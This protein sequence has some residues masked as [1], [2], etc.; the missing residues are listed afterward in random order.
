MVTTLFAEIRGFTPFAARVTPAEAVEALNEIFARV[1]EIVGGE[2]G[3]VDRVLGDGMLAIF[4]APYACEQHASAAARAALEVR[5]ALAT[6]LGHRERRGKALEVGVGLN[7]GS[8]IAGAVAARDRSA[9]TVL[10]HAVNVAAR[11]AANADAS[12]ILIGPGTAALLPSDFD[13]RDRGT[14]VLPGIGPTAVFEL[15]R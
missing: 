4:G 12:Q 2:Q 11:L 9:Y 7:T 13:V 10:G 6:P 3:I 1:C 14:L 8:V 15:V 5:T